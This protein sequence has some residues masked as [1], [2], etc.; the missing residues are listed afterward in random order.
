MMDIVTSNMP[1]TARDFIGERPIPE[2][3]RVRRE[4][5]R[6]AS[7]GDLAVSSFADDPAKR[8]AYL[9]S[10]R[11]PDTPLNAAMQRYG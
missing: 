5:D 4:S 6:G 10:Q 7:M 8:I 2:N 1:S 3:M 11:F 9:A